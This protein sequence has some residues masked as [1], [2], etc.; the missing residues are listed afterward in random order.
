MVNLTPLGWYWGFQVEFPALRPPGWLS[1]KE[2]TCQTGDVGSIPGEGTSSL[3]QYSCLVNPMDRGAWWATVHRVAKTWTRLSNWAQIA[4]LQDNLVHSPDQRK[5]KYYGKFLLIHHENTGS[6]RSW[7]QIRLNSLINKKLYFETHVCTHTD[8]DTDIHTQTHAH[9]SSGVAW[10]LSRKVRQGF[11][12][13]S[14]CCLP[15][16]VFQTPTDWPAP[17]SETAAER[18]PWWLSRTVPMW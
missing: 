15:C 14:T 7:G 3:L 6:L 11:T 5:R 4:G 13:T 10:L 1:G 2:S 16:R 8:T 12:D 17:L 18:R 9:P